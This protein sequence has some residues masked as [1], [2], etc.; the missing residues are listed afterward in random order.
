M[1]TIAIISQKGGTGKTTLAIHLAAA[2]ERK[3]DPI[4]LGVVAEGLGVLWSASESTILTP[5][6]PPGLARVVPISFMWEQVPR[7]AQ[8]PGA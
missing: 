2:A 4:V 3:G 6:V 7:C 5:Y 1:T 8:N